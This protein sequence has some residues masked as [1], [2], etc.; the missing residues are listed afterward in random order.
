M[1]EFAAQLR[2]PLATARHWRATGQGPRGRRVGRRV[3]YL[4][5]EVDAYIAEMFAASIRPSQPTTVDSDVLG[6]GEMGGSNAA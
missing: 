4:K 5:S 6:G 2:I 1:T 3:L